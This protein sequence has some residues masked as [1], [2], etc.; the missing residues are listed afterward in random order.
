[1]KLS[2]RNIISVAI[3]VASS[4]GVHARPTFE[5]KGVDKAV[6][7]SQEKV[8]NK[9]REEFMGLQEQEEFIDITPYAPLFDLV[10]QSDLTD[11]CNLYPEQCSYVKTLCV[12]DNNDSYCA[13][14]IYQRYVEASNNSNNAINSYIDLC[15]VCLIDMANEFQ[16]A[17]Q[18]EEAKYEMKT[19]AD[20]CKVKL[21]MDS[22]IN[23]GNQEDGEIISTLASLVPI[24]GEK[25]KRHYGKIHSFKNPEAGGFVKSNGKIKYGHVGINEKVNTSIHNKYRATTAQKRQEFEEEDDMIILDNIKTKIYSAL[26]D[27]K[28]LALQKVSTIFSNLELNVSVMLEDDLFISDPEAT[29]EKNVLTDDILSSIKD[30]LNSDVSDIAKE[31]EGYILDDTITSVVDESKATP[32]PEV[33]EGEEGEVEDDDIPTGPVDDIFQEAVDIPFVKKSE[34]GEDIFEIPEEANDHDE[35]AV[36]PPT[37]T[38]TEIIPEP[39]E[40]TA[41]A[42]EVYPEI[43]TDGYPIVESGTEGDDEIQEI[44]GILPDESSDVEVSSDDDDDEFADDES[45]EPV[46]E[47]ESK[48]PIHDE[49]IDEGPHHGQTPFVKP[50]VP[51]ITPTKPQ[52]PDKPWKFGFKTKTEQVSPQKKPTIL[53]SINKLFGENKNNYTPSTPE[54]A[55][56]FYTPIK[57]WVVKKSEYVVSHELLNEEIDPEQAEI[58]DTPVQDASVYAPEPLTEDDKSIKLNNPENHRDNNEEE[59]FEIGSKKVSFI[60]SVHPTKPSLNFRDNDNRDTH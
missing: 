24:E 58:E 17:S 9:V 10:C 38:V 53:K 40:T 29:R 11:W 30:I 36:P 26:S 55:A 52:R 18:D 16:Q 39:T 41:I 56:R 12:R 2:T 5:L 15:D 23:E 47:D 42:Q 31:I 45:E 35:A 43:P 3:L 46:P 1:M 49:I 19:L 34:D 48:N 8:N 54:E 6:H 59:T 13:F 21:F 22:Y 28:E 60:N 50:E 44:E 20:M 32:T 33:L 27:I 4:L 51:V 57:K 7:V 14:D 25:L 37:S